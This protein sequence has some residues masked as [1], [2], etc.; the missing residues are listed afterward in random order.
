MRKKLIL[1]YTAPRYRPK[2]KQIFTRKF[3]KNFFEKYPEF[4]DLSEKFTIHEKKEFIKFFNECLG[5]MAIEK[6]DG[7]S[8]PEGLGHIY[9]GT[10]DAKVKINNKLSNELG[11]NI[12]HANHHS[13]GKLLKIMYTSYPKNYNF[14]NKEL[15]KFKSAQSFKD[16][17]SKAFRVNWPRYREL[18]NF[19][20]IEARQFRFYKRENVDPNYVIKK[21]NKK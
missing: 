7:V 11:Y 15:W 3:F 2:S 16:K 4:E 10:I 9:L 6:R 5:D 21:R 20:E 17:A 8:L 1:D 14:E 12:N 18:E 13:D 19:K